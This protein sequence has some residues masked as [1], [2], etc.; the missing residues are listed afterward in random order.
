MAGFALGLFL[1]LP[2]GA[3]ATLAIVWWFDLE[4][5]DD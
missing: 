2:T 4:L 3:I 5:R 1:G